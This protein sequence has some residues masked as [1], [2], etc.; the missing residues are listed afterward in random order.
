MSLGCLK[1]NQKRKKCFKN[2][3]RSDIETAHHMP[4]WTNLTMVQGQYK[5][6][7]IQRDYASRRQ[8]QKGFWPQKNT[9]LRIIF[10]YFILLSVFF[11]WYFVFFSSVNLI[12]WH[13]LIM[14]TFISNS[15]WPRHAWHPKAKD[16]KSMTKLNDRK[17]PWYRNI[18]GLFHQI[19]FI[20]NF[21]QIYF[22]FQ[23]YLLFIPFSCYV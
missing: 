20:L 14:A 21:F 15:A 2:N 4:H 7:L 8:K 11:G 3:T 23:T 13:I 16:L 12:H 17:I 5:E 6:Y 1:I 19:R 9:L 22:I 18:I 10:F